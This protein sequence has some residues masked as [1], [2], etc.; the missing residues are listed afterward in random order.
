V[1]VWEGAPTALGAMADGVSVGYVNVLGGRVGT[2]VGGAARYAKGPSEWDVGWA[3]RWEERG[4]EWAD[5]RLERRER[6]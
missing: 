5:W 3:D 4:V 1:C 6:S 2:R